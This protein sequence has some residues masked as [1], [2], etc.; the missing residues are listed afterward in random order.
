MGAGIEAV[1]SAAAAPPGAHYSQAIRAGGRIWTAG[2]VGTEPVTG[3]VVPGGVEPQIH[4]AIE[5]IRETLAAA[6][7]DLAHVVK[8]TC[9]VTRREDFER[10]DPIYREYFPDPPPARTTIV[11]GLVRDEF[12]FE[13]EA[14]AVVP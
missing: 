9:F 1:E 8:T 6:G 10:L 13:I 11:C 4:R 3:R 7:T 2:A 14:V 12:L 5:N